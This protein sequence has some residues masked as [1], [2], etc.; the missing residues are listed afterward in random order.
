VKRPIEWRP[1]DDLFWQRT[2]RRIAWPNLMLSVPGLLFSFAVWMGWSVIIVEMQNLGFPLTKAQ[3][4]SLPAIA[5]LAGATLRIPNSFA[6]ALCGGK[7]AVLTGVALLLIPAFGIGIALRDISTPYTTLAVLAALSGF[8]GGNFASSMSNISF[9]FPKRLQGTALGINAGVG[10]LGVSVAQVLLPLVFT[11]SLFGTVAGAPLPLPSGAGRYLQNGGLV[12]IIPL[13]VILVLG[14]KIMTNLPQHPFGSAPKAIGRALWINLLGLLASFGGISLM[15][16]LKAPIVVVL[17]VTILMVLA[18]FRFLSPPQMRESIA[19]QFAIFPHQHTWTMT[20]LYVMTFGSFIGYSAIF[21]KLIQDV[22]GQLPGGAPNPDAPSPFAFAWLGPLVG[23]L[24]RPIGGWLSDKLGGARVTHWTTVAMIGSAVAVG[25]LVR[26]ARQAPQPQDY[27]V[28]FLL[29]FL[30]LFV[31][32]G[33]GNGST[34][35]MIPLIFKPE[36]A[37]P[38]LGWTSAVGAYG[39][40]IVPKIFGSQIEAGQPDYA[41][42]GFAVYYLSC[43]A[44]NW[45]YYARRGAAVPC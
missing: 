29:L 43:L 28:P 7:N 40:F 27:F 10:N 6:V 44:V 11:F 15:I 36:Q 31:T 14:L 34:F 45:W 20:W 33:I 41:F 17:V 4:Y 12:W 35:R 19:R 18:A 16:G 1:E 37:G 39:S 22:F 23:S 13:L 9:F 38:V 2:G 30:F 25:V 26:L 3:L 8:G 32:T 24:V 42:Y 21:P 5:G